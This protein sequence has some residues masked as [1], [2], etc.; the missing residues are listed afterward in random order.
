MSLD[1]K[2]LLGKPGV[3]K[4]SRFCLCGIFRAGPA[5]GVSWFHKRSGLIFFR[6]GGGIY[7]YTSY[8]S[9]RALKCAGSTSR[10]CF[11]F[12]VY[13]E[14][15]TWISKTIYKPLDYN[16][17]VPPKLIPSIEVFH[18]KYVQE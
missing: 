7:K 8:L 13:P 9:V 18:P 3:K 11:G 17:Q 6:E 2:M 14:G 12:S 10:H 5:A 15:E 16:E 1:V 4:R